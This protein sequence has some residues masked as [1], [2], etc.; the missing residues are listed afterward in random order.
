MGHNRTNITESDSD[1]NLTAHRCSDTVCPSLPSCHLMRS[2]AKRSTEDSWTMQRSQ[3]SKLALSLAGKIRF[4]NHRRR[5]EESS[6]H[7]EHGA[8]DR[9]ASGAVAR[10]GCWR[11]SRIQRST[12]VASRRASGTRPTAAGTFGLSHLAGLSWTILCSLGR[13]VL[14]SRG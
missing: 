5:H 4:G 2:P 1:R 13:R 3:S 7:A 9:P 8:Q 11:V 6:L 10:C 14:G 12:G